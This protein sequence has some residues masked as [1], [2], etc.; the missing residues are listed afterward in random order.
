MIRKSL[1]LPPDLWQRLDQLAVATRSHYRDRPSWRSMIRRIASGEIR[2]A[3]RRASQ[4]RTGRAG[5][6]GDAT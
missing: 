6:V 1:P 4:R 5:L 3:A 2:L